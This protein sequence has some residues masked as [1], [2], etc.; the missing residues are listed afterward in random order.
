MLAQMVRGVEPSYSSIPALQVSRPG[1]P[2]ALRTAGRGL[3]GERSANTQRAA[4]RTGGTVCRPPRRGRALRTQPDRSAGARPRL[5]RRQGGGRPAREQGRVGILPD[6]GTVDRHGAPVRTGRR[7]AGCASRH[8]DHREH[9]SGD[10]ASGTITS[11]TSST[12]VTRSSAAPHRR[13]WRASRTAPP[14]CSRLSG[15][16]RPARPA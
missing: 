13:S 10:L 8:G 4:R 15:P 11:C 5:R 3:S 12:N 16:R 9:G 1:L 14:P 6:D 2:Q 7:R